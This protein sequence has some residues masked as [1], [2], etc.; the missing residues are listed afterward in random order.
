MGAV[1]RRCSRS[2]SG[3]VVAGLV[4]SALL[5]TAC[6]AQRTRPAEQADIRLPAC[7]ECAYL[8][9]SREG[10]IWISDSFGSIVRVD[11]TGSVA[12][13]PLPEEEQ[14]DLDFPGDI[15]EGPDHAMWFPTT[16]AIGRIDSKGNITSPKV[17]VS[18]SL[19]VI[20]S[21]DGGL[22]YAD[23][24]DSP[25]R[26]QR[27]T[28]D[29]VIATSLPLT[30]RRDDFFELGGIA[31]GPDRALW[32][33]ESS[34]EPD[35]LPDAVGRVTR[36]GDYEQWPLPKPRSGPTRIVAGSDD[37]LWF[38]EEGGHR[39]GRI[40]AAGEITEYAL[41]PEVSPTD[42]ASGRDRALWFTS[43]TC[44]GRITTEGDVAM[45]PVARAKGLV[46]IEAAPDGSFWLLDR[47]GRALVHFTP[48]RPAEGSG[49]G[50]Q[51][52]SVAAQAGSTRAVLTYK[53]LDR[54]KE[55]G[56]FFTDARIAI[57]REG[58]EVFSEAVPSE[59]P[60]SNTAY[61]AYGYSD[62]FAVRDLDG[63]GEPEVRLEL[64][65]N[66]THCCEWSR[67]YR[68]EPPR[69]TYVA[70]THFWGDALA[71]PNLQD[72]DDDGRPEFVSKDDRFAELTGYAGVVAPI[73]LWSY[74]QGKFSDVT[75][76]YPKLI[77][78]DAARL[79]RSYVAH[80]G[81]TVRYVLAAWAADQY[82]LG[83]EALVD[84]VFSEALQDG[85]LAPV[86]GE[87]EDAASYLTML[88]NFLRK[89][90]YIRG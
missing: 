56:D 38:V 73:Q 7:G 81:E 69:G 14:P 55:V 43:D 32:F 50:C 61:T 44:I 34:Y 25:A 53:R 26:I 52:P 65:W 21:V 1:K 24:S 16:G 36:D 33:T 63:D 29:G 68:F 15:V 75:R 60:H 62:D 78:Q 18:P 72:V 58:K 5:V 45:W 28:M 9:L 23:S 66:G 57:S 54:L 77:E 13:Y 85:S 10:V 31:P 6:G 90:G 59:P 79:W 30:S 51:P 20:T 42:I 64:D 37:A 82:M 47:V 74:D 70:E 87:S 49:T 88:R 46:A 76:R 67:I 71:S 35:K 86:L 40:T 19:S 12:D 83:R 17:G 11:P 48:P 3:F 84:Q 8:A 22:W 2:H 39:I 89:A 80:R 41:R 27:M 4:F